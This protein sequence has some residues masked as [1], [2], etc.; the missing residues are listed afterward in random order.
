MCQADVG[1]G[2]GR[3]AERHYQATIPISAQQENTQT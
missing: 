1:L 3:G 2:A